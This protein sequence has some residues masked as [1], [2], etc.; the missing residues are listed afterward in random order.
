[1][2][3]D[4]LVVTFDG[5]PPIVTPLDG[6]KAPWKSGVSKETYYVSSALAGDTLHQV[7]TASD[8]HRND[9][10]VFV[11]GGERMELHVVLEAEHLPGPL[12]YTLEFR[13]LH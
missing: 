13:R 1:M 8:G 10:F 6:T 12:D 9:D 3:D 11:D 2:R 5:H 7:I 4:S